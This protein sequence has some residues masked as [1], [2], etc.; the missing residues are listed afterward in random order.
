M[1]ILSITSDTK[2]DCINN[3]GILDLEANLHEKHSIILILHGAH[4]TD[5]IIVNMLEQW[6]NH[7]LNMLLKH[8]TKKNS[9]SFKAHHSTYQIGNS[10]C[11][12]VFC[13][14]QTSPSVSEILAPGTTNHCPTL[15][16]QN[17]NFT[18]KYIILSIITAV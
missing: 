7:K 16:M 11:Y 8:Q 2:F 17:I 14:F 15:E 9:A 18:W 10:Q 3:F 4:A 5:I 13:R 6:S 12:H 1:S